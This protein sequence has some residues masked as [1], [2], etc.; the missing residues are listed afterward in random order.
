MSLCI[1]AGRVWKP[2][3]ATELAPYFTDQ[4]LLFLLPEEEPQKPVFGKKELSWE[5]D[6]QMYSKF[7]DRKVN[8]IE[9]FSKAQGCLQ[10]WIRV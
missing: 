6:M 1:H 3:M 5:E 2:I 10:V 9:N 4:L 8:I 7:L